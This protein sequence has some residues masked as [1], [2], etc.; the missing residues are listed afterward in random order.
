MLAIDVEEDHDLAR[1]EL[2]KEAHAPR[3]V[4]EAFDRRGVIG[5]HSSSCERPTWQRMRKQLLHRARRMRPQQTGRARRARRA[6]RQCPAMYSFARS[7]SRSTCE[8][9]RCAVDH[10]VRAQ[11][12]MNI[13]LRTI[14]VQS[15]EPGFLG[16]F[17]LVSNRIRNV[18]NPRPADWRARP[19]QLT[20]FFSASVG[21]LVTAAG[22]PPLMVEKAAAR[23][24]KRDAAREVKAE[25][26]RDEA[27]KVAA[28]EAARDAVLVDVPCLFV[29]PWACAWRPRT[30]VRGA[31]PQI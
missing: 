22:M 13:E 8:P 10:A 9:E 12:A 4:G 15:S 3:D 19:I 1:D 7:I 21:V 17:S 11:R 16:R 6:Q 5:S 23:E 20:V 25:K 29:W 30:L 2:L 28:R 27:E 26:A 18:F 31:S 14:L 24:A